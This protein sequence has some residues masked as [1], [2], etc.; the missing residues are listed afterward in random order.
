MAHGNRGISILLLHHQLGHRLAHDVASAQDNTLLTAGFYLIMLQQ[1]EDSKRSS[2]DETRHTQRHS[3]HIH[4]M[5]AI[6]ILAIVYRH[7]N[8]LLVDVL[9]QRQL[10]DETIHVSILVE[11]IYTQQKLLLSNILLKTDQRRFESALFACQ[12]LVL[13]IGFA[14]TI[15]AHQH[16]H[17]MWLFASCGYNLSHLLGNLFLNSGCCRLSVY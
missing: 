12:H 10:H 7:G 8:L 4:G 16:S 5:E 17:Q 3:T 14:A 13:H 9:R 15:V 6:H 2:R 1:G 11:L